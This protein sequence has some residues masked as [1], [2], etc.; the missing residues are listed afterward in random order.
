LRTA[1]SSVYGA[2]QRLTS[3]EQAMTLLGV[4]AVKVL[5]LGFS[6]AGSLLKAPTGRLDAS[7]YWR[8]SLCSAA[9]ARSLARAKRFKQIDTCFLAG[10][11][12]DSG[13]LVLDQVLGP[14]YASIVAKASDHESLSRF[15]AE[16]L[17]MTH[18]D[19]SVILAEHWHLPPAVRGPIGIHHR[20]EAAQGENSRQTAD[21][22]WLAGRCADAIV[23]P[24]PTDAL[25]EVRRHCAEHYAI[26]GG[27]CDEILAGIGEAADLLSAS[28]DLKLVEVGRAAKGP[29]GADQRRAPRIAAKGS[30]TIVPCTQEGL[31]RPVRVGIRDL[32]RNGIGL[33]HSQPMPIGGQFVVRLP[34]Q[35]AQAVPII[36][37]IVRCIGKVPGS[38]EIGARIAAVHRQSKSGKAGVAA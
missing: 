34:G 8:R 9:A 11:L 19:A 16:S 12:M 22:I 33:V 18:A 14:E 26:E 10:F 29:A 38:F 7:A 32:S 15:E 23:E 27:R 2:G 31:G 25:A 17:D 36:Y 35:A 5:V 3:L 4:R 24:D 37:T 1:D 6:L 20:P 28:L 21:V 30:I 13:M